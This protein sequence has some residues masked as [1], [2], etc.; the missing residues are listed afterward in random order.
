[1]AKLTRY[2]CVTEQCTNM[3]EY[4]G[5]G[6]YPTRCDEC[7]ATRKRAYN[8]ARRA[9]VNFNADGPACSAEGCDRVSNAR[10]MCLMHFKRTRP[11]TP[12]KPR[13]V[14][15]VVCGT[16]V[17][18]APVSANT[19][20]YGHTCSRACATSLIKREVCE[21]PVDHWARM[22]GATCAVN[23]RECA[24]CGSPMTSRHPARIYCGYACKHPSTAQH[25]D[26]RSCEC[27]GS[28]F[29]PTSRASRW[30]SPRCTKTGH[31]RIR[32]AREYQAQGSYTTKQVRNLWHL[33]DKAC[34]YC[35]TPTPF[36]QIEAEHVVAIS[37]G[38]ANDITNLLVACRACNTGKATLSL[39]EWAARRAQQGKPIVTIEWSP[40]DPR[41]K[42]LK[43]A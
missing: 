31:R 11:R 43:L 29:S 15:C 23:V 27:C 26:D 42:H 39:A 2:Q 20:R 32:R 41:Y 16:Q 35:S 40:D 24:R 18:R 6:R 36:E 28:T 9:A 14:T 33:F 30:C 38:G 19:R 3:M 12:D 4:G 5:M 22:W 7:T 21:L 34:A 25:R 1:M 13:A 37:R 17:W 8:K 10:G